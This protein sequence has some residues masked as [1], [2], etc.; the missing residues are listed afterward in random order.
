MIRED[1]YFTT[2][3]EKG[4]VPLILALGRSDRPLMK[5]ELPCL[6]DFALER[7][8][9]MGVRDGLLTIEIVPRPRRTYLIGLTGTGMEVESLLSEIDDTVSPGVGSCRK[10]VAMR[11]ADPVLRRMHA[12]GWLIQSDLLKIV[13]SYRS[14]IRVMKA[15]E[16]DGLTVSEEDGRNVRYG[17]TA[18]GVFASERLMKVYRLIVRARSDTV[19][20]GRTRAIQESELE[21]D[22]EEPDRRPGFMEKSYALGSSPE[23]TSCYEIQRP[24]SPSQPSS[25]S[26]SWAWCPWPS[27]RG[28]TLPH[29]IRARTP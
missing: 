12:D 29:W 2:I 15:L 23:C 25:W 28:S 1:P 8:L 11:Y 27:C 3:S 21:E 13:D 22:E 7:V 4:A 10:S 26:S 14:L 20:T 19:K 9:G 16:D 17:L 6:G 18:L 5:S 24:S